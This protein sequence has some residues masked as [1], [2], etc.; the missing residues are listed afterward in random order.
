MKHLFYILP[1]LSIMTSYGQ[2]VSIPDPNFK[3]RL[4]THIPVIDINNNG[5][6]EVSEAEALSTT[7]DLGE[8]PSSPGNIM[9]LTGIEAFLN[10]TELSCEYNQIIT[11]DLSTNTSITAIN[12]TGNN[13]T[14]INVT[15]NPL[16]EILDASENT[17]TTV[18]LSN[19]SQLS[20]FQS[21]FG[22][23]SSI[24]LSNNANLLYCYV[25][26][27]QLTELNLDGNPLLDGIIIDDNNI[28]SLYVEH[29][30]LL[31]FIYCR[32]NALTSLNVSNNDGLITLDCK[33]NTQLTYLNIR[34][35]ANNLLNITGSGASCNFE[36]LPLL[37]TV[38]L[39]NT[40]SPLASFITS[41]IEHEVTYTETCT[42]GL[43]GSTRD[44]QLSVNP[45]PTRD[46]IQLKASN[47]IVEVRLYNIMGQL[48]MKKTN[49]SHLT[50]MDLSSYVNG[51]YI[52][53]VKDLASNTV[54][55][56][57][58]KI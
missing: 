37:D 32:N 26:G 7:L 18:D 21:N 43:E 11:L 27:N 28:N 13:I 44:L 56:K 48:M 50:N 33:G 47:E 8:S 19:N 34:S 53:V 22:H 14:S 30:S 45:N 40:N 58:L 31:R 55:H 46:V 39:D 16:L 36:N 41:Q 17:F 57:I 6:I 10:I 54:I 2:I 4:L 24:D 25:Q 42:F 1:L 29:N 20:F 49:N 51:L 15:N 5:E 38:C 23:L 35:G 12:C 3:S 52:L 9:D